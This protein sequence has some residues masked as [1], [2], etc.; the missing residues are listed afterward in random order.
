M[1]FLKK[2]KI[3]LSVL[4]LSTVA[5]SEIYRTVGPRGNFATVTEAVTSLLPLTDDVVLEVLVSSDGISDEMTIEASPDFNGYSITVYGT[6]AEISSVTYY[7]GNEVEFNLDKDLN[8]RTTEYINSAGLQARKVTDNTGSS[9]GNQYY[10]KN[11]LGSTMLMLDSDGDDVIQICDYFPYGKKIDEL[12]A[13]GSEKPETH[14]FTEKELDRYDMDVEE[15]DDGAGLYYF[16]ARYYDPDV[17]KWISTDP[18]RE[19]FDSYRYTTNPI[20]FIDPTGLAENVALISS[21]DFEKQNTPEQINAHITQPMDALVRKFEDVGGSMDWDFAF[22][23][24]YLEAALADN[25]DL[26][27]L[28]VLA[29]GDVTGAASVRTDLQRWINSDK[30]QNILGGREITVHLYACAQKGANWPSNFNTSGSGKGGASS[31]QLLQNLKTDLQSNIPKTK[32]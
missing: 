22:T 12:A 11:H 19:F 13:V 31:V 24:G 20:A 5:F 6:S 29:H 3:I 23:E 27:D 9:G 15:N 7:I 8:T 10:V 28:Y 30:F 21:T 17:G 26:V 2:K 4:L 14:T 32:K 1:N 16:G 25:P 18:I